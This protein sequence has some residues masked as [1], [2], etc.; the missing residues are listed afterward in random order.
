MTDNSS[1]PDA[2]ARLLTRHQPQLYAVVFA[3]VG[4]G[5]LAHDVFQDTNRVLWEQAR[6]YDPK[7]PF[8]PWAVAIARNQVRAARQKRRRD[9][10]DFGEDIEERLAERMLARAERQDERQV[11][12][13]DCM[14][15]L[16]SHQ[17]ELLERRYSIGESIA[18]IAATTA[19]TANVV[20][21]TLHRV[22]KL[23][24]EC[25]R[26]TLSQKERA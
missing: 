6:V 26:N 7:L 12:L 10:L 13:A 3:L 25:I 8:L 9:R 15:R 1:Y 14:Q 20:A 17:R 4:D 23:L 24:A 5:H 2:F 21:V 11:A 19:R 18:E 22:R 16:P